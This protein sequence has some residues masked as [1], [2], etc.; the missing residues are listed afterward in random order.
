MQREL[1]PQLQKHQEGAYISLSFI[2]LFLK[3]TLVEYLIVLNSNFNHQLLQ[4]IKKKKNHQLQTQKITTHY[5][6]EFK[7][8]KTTLVHECNECKFRSLPNNFNIGLE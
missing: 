3:E 8:A 2:Y 7:D 1:G 6:R 5:K 4:K